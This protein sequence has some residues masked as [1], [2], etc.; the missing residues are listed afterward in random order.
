M[1]SP[2]PICSNIGLMLSEPSNSRRVLCPYGRARLT[3]I[4]QS[5]RAVDCACRE[6]NQAADQD[7]LPPVHPTQARVISEI[8]QQLTLRKDEFGDQFYLSR[9]RRHPDMAQRFSFIDRSTRQAALWGALHSITSTDRPP[10]STAKSLG[11]R[12]AAD[13]VQGED[14]NKFISVLIDTLSKFVGDEFT[15]TIRATCAPVLND[16]STEMIEYDKSA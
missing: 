5:T 9:F 4:D 8:L 12:H 14:Y 15:S 16:L 3:A 13:G 1:K 7:R 6:S 2:V 11:A 10:V